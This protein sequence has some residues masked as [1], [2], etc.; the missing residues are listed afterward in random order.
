MSLTLPKHNGNQWPS[1][2]GVVR[3]VEARLHRTPTANHW[4]AKWLQTSSYI[5]SAH[6]LKPTH[7]Y[8]LRKGGA[9][10]WIQTQA[11]CA[12]VWPPQAPPSCSPADSSHIHWLWPPNARL[13]QTFQLSCRGVCCT[14]CWFPL[15]CCASL[16]LLSRGSR[17]SLW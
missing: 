15:A 10:H 7:T 12:V 16:F 14:S 5:L 3:K 11:G 1:S 13:R 9:V 17:P 4:N 2:P 6:I 8:D